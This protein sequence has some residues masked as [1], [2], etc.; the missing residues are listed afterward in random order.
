[1]AVTATLTQVLN[2][3]HTAED[4]VSV[5]TDQVV[6]GSNSF[7]TMT[8]ALTD[9]T[10]AGQINKVYRLYGTLTAS[11]STTIDLSGSLTNFHGDAVVFTG[12]KLLCL[13]IVSPDGT[14]KL[15]IGNAA[16]NSFQGPL[17]ASATI[18]VFYDVVLKNWSA[19]G[20]AVTNSSTDNLKI[21]NPGAGSV[22]YCLVVGGI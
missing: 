22:S 6:S 2:L 12:V 8:Q 20:W 3:Q 5:V 10:A 4:S 7:P 9:G 1:M 21:N 11:S 17:T 15:Q 13:A 18:D 14:K 16:S 19:A